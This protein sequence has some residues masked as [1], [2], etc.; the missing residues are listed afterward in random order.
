MV[1]MPQIRPVKV[2]EPEEI[3]EEIKKSPLKRGKTTAAGSKSIGLKRQKTIAIA[4]ESNEKKT[5]VAALTAGLANLKS[6]LEAITP[7]A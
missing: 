4:E 2:V 6:P 1:Y 7:P 3:V 5:S